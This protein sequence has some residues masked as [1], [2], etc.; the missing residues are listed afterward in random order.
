MAFLTSWTMAI[1]FLDHGYLL[2]VWWQFIFYKM[3]QFFYLTMKK[4]PFWTWKILHYDHGKF[5]F[6]PCEKKLDHDK[7]NSCMLANLFFKIVSILFLLTLI[8]FFNMP[9]FIFRPCERERL[10]FVLVAGSNEVSFIIHPTVVV[11]NKYCVFE[12]IIGNVKAHSDYI[13]LRLFIHHQGIS[14]IL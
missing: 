9:N 11:Y 3:C 10:L 4:N 1:L 7:F 6:T 14:L 12:W 13:A 2:H 8:C 5:I